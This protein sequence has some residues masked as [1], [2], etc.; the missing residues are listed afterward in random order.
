MRRLR[1]GEDVPLALGWLEATVRPHY[2]GLPL[3]RLDAVRAKAGKPAGS[4]SCGRW[5]QY[6]E[7]R[8]FGQKE[9]RGG[10]PSGVA[11]LRFAGDP[12]GRSGVQCYPSAPDGVLPPLMVEGRSAQ[13]SDAP[14][15]RECERVAV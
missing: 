6:P 9:R 14:A 7:E 15:P 13:T 11:Q 4:I 5:A 12:A 10:T 2:G 1:A 8:S 3:A